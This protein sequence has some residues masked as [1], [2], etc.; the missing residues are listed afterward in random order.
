MFLE[1]EV[2]E[3]TTSSSVCGDVDN[4]VAVDKF[5]RLEQE[6][7]KLRAENEARFLQPIQTFLD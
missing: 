3:D 2:P 6:M 4:N 7:E 5:R 1:M